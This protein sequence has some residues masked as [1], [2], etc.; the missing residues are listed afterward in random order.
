[1]AEYQKL[2]PCVWFFFEK[3]CFFFLYIAKKN[4]LPNPNNSFKY[5][6][7]IKWDQEP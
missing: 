1:M 2:K 5:I 6:K 4:Q 7:N 3:N